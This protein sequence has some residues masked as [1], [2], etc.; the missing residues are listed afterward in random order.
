M[1]NEIKDKLQEIEEAVTLL[2]T[3]VPR[4]DY[5]AAIGALQVCQNTIETLT[6]AL[7][8]VKPKSVEVANARTILAGLE[9]IIDT[10]FDEYTADKMEE[11]YNFKDQPRRGEFSSVF[12]HIKKDYK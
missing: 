9:A 6:T 5:D 12:G 10:K 8:K 1:I 3:R 7:F 4:R 2:G 11:T